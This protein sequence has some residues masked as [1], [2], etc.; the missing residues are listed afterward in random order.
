MYKVFT[1]GFSNVQDT[2]RGVSNVQGT[3]RGRF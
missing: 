2:Y 1:G 3:Y